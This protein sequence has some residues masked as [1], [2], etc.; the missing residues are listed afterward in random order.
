VEFITLDRDDR[1]AMGDV[2]TGES[3]DRMLTKLNRE[4]IS[5]RAIVPGT[6]VVAAHVYAVY[7]KLESFVSEVQLPYHA[8]LEL[9]KLNPKVEVV[10]NAKVLLTESKQEATFI[11][12]N[13]TKKGEIIDIKYNPPGYSLLSRAYPANYFSNSN[14]STP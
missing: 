1:G 9:I 13:V 6:Y 12:F 7:N 4:T 5:I 8:E 3:G 11:S 14:W 2:Y 10:A